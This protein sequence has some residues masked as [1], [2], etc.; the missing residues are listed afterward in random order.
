M[1]GKVFVC[2]ISKLKMTWIQ[3]L[4]FQFYREELEDNKSYKNARLTLKNNEKVDVNLILLLLPCQFLK[5]I[6]ENCQECHDIE[7]IMPD[8]EL[9]DIKR[10]LEVLLQGKTK[11]RQSI[12][13]LELVFDMLRFDENTFVLD[14]LDSTAVS[15]T[16]LTLP[17]ILLV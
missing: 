6:L 14:D 3:K 11:W 9:V 5:E 13:F 15:Y 1:E 7:V 12:G 16:H 2:G 10:L 8:V 4:P 17:T